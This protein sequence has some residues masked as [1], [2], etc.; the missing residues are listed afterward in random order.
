MGDADA[1]VDI[2]LERAEPTRPQA[3]EIQI[4]V[5][6]SDDRS[7]MRR[8]GQA[9]DSRVMALDRQIIDAVD[10]D[11]T[12]EQRIEAYADAAAIHDRVTEVA[13][14]RASRSARKSRQIPEG[15]VGAE[16]ATDI[17]PEIDAL[18]RQPRWHRLREA[19][20]SGC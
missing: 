18:E 4:A 19:T 9:G 2:G 16:Y 14:L 7:D 20:G 10:G 8:A 13:R 5:H 3:L 17:A 6:Q 15:R 1:G 11:V 12:A